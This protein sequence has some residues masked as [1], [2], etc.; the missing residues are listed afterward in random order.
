MK[1]RIEEIPLEDFDL[2]LAGMR[3]INPDW[4]LRVQ[5]SMWLHGQ[6][7]PVVAREHEGRFMLLDGYKR[8]YSAVELMMETLQCQVLDIDLQQAKLMILSYNRPHQ[9]ME[10]WEEA[11]VLEDLLKTHNLNQQS[12]SRLTGYSRAWVSRRL[13]LI[14]KIDDEVASEIRMGTITSSQARVLVKLPRGNQADVARVITQWHLSSRQSSALVDAFLEAKGE[15]TR[16]Y[17]LSHPELVLEEKEPEVPEEVDDDRLSRYGNDLMNSME[18]ALYF[19]QITLSR[20]G[21]PRLG[22]LNKME[23]VIIAPVLKKVLNYAEKLTKAN[24]RL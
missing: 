2:S 15:D 22:E 19:I 14:G 1:P 3:I 8:Y 17:I 11:M 7:Q 18:L 23:R 4:V 12:L 16:Q 10:V 20:L 5:N 9:S 24:T 6:L 21:D 13:S